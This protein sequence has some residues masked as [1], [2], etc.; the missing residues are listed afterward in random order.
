MLCKFKN[1][2]VKYLNFI[3]FKW[4]K[5]QFLYGKVLLLAISSATYFIYFAQP[6]TKIF[7]DHVVETRTET[8]LP[9]SMVP[10]ETI[11]I[12]THEKLFMGDN[13]S[14]NG[15]DE[16][17]TNVLEIEKNNL[18]QTKESLMKQ[19]QLLKKERR[20]DKARIDT[21]SKHF[22]KQKTNFEANITVNQEFFKYAS[23][24]LRN[25]SYPGIENYTRYA[26]AR[27]GLLPLINVEPLKPEF[28]PVIN[29]VLSFRY[30]I[31]IGPC[32]LDVI[33]ADQKV[34]VAV[35]SAPGN[36]EKR[37]I[38]RQTWKIH[39]KAEYEKGLLGIV[40]FGFMLGLTTSDVMQA[41][42]EEESKMY[43]DIIQIG[44]SDFYRNLSL[45]V[46]GIFNWL[47]R[48]C[49]KVDFIFKIDDDVYVNVR[50]L[51]HFVQQSHHQS[52]PSMFGLP[53][54]YLS[55]NRGTIPS[56]F[57]II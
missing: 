8:L 19:L 34:F 13:I 32:R 29:D 20:L 7:I 48:N 10:E 43:G 35:V 27:L 54:E 41:Q 14:P 44:V 53:S 28:G 42:I 17:A 4:L 46:A 40:G 52:N 45:K 33:T 55:P 57:R 56:T 25:T 26:V 11:N 38:I 1:I 6:T 15:R 37:K 2:C 49:N 12:S 22:E 47:Y 39:L 23:L 50:N 51:A 31:T 16:I 24:V 36:F 9:S 21:L 18:P 5:A 3:I 30:P